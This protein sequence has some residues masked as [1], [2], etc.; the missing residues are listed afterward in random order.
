MLNYCIRRNMNERIFHIDGVEPD[1]NVGNR[2][3]TEYV[4]SVRTPG[5][6]YDEEKSEV[7]RT[8]I[9]IENSR[10]GVNERGEI[11]LYVAPISEEE[12]QALR[13]RKKK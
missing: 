5:A 7:V 10:L 8:D 1:D 3:G 6:Y 13:E 11:V 12:L 9:F 2:Q 4:G